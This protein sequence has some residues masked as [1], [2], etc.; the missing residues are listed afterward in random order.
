MPSLTTYH[1]CHTPRTPHCTHTT[2]HT[3][4]TAHTPHCTHTTLHT[5]HYTH[6]TL[7]TSHC[8]HTT[9]HTHHTAHTPHYSTAR[10]SAADGLRKI[11]DTFEEKVNLKQCCSTTLGYIFILK[12][13]FTSSHVRYRGVCSCWPN[14]YIHSTGL[15]CCRKQ[16]D[17][18]WHLSSLAT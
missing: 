11:A 9:L 5:P 3:H 1:T 6:T 7:H 12:S 18:S 2:L 17:C 16:D 10:N 4:H 13:Q 8:T 14:M 15:S